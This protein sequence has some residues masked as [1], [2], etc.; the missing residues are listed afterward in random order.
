[1]I[2]KEANSLPSFP[3]LIAYWIINIR[4]IKER[5]KQN[6]PVWSG[7]I[8]SSPVQSSLPGITHLQMASGIVACRLPGTIRCLGQTL[9]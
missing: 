7:S 8:R 4:N 6:I 3:M 9:Y 1:M 2:V 5:I